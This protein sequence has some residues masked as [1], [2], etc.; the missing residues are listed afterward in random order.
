MNSIRLNALSFNYNDKSV[1]KKSIKK[2]NRSFIKSFISLFDNQ[3]LVL[4][5]SCVKEQ[6]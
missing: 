3:E 6:L 5:D 1:V 2:S 4:F